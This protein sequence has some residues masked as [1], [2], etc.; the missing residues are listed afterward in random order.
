MKWTEHIPKMGED[1]LPAEG[2]KITRMISKKIFP[3]E[4]RAC[5]DL[6]H[7]CRRRKNCYTAFEIWSFHR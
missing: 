3:L 4:A 6:I 1:R 5:Y 2:K 7:V